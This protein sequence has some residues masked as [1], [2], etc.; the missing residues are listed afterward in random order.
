MLLL[1]LCGCRCQME[2]LSDVLIVEAEPGLLALRFDS[3]GRVS[4]RPDGTAVFCR[5]HAIP[6]RKMPL[7]EK[8]F[9]QHCPCAALERISNRLA[10]K[11]F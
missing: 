4:R 8:V 7:S 9:V 1:N 3:N 2:H 5:R 11:A 10:Q 6:C